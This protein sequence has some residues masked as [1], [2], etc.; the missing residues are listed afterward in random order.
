MNREIYEGF[1]LN[2]PY[3]I[4]SLLLILHLCLCL[5]LI[6]THSHMFIININGYFE[7]AMMI[8]ENYR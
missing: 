4:G 1:L 5:S 3:H 2:Y 8:T 7:H 6:L